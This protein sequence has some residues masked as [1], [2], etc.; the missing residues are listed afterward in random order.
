MLSLIVG[1][2]VL[3]F[4]S[5]TPEGFRT[6][7][8][9]D[10]SSDLDI[11]ISPVTEGYADL[12][13]TRKGKLPINLDQWVEP[14]WEDCP[15]MIANGYPTEHKNEIGDQIAAPMISATAEVASRLGGQEKTFVLHSFLEVPHNAY[16]SGMSGGPVYVPV[17]ESELTPTGIIFEGGPSSKDSAQESIYSGPNSIFIRA[18][19]LSPS[20][21]DEWLDRCGLS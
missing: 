10:E 14:D 2:A 1:R 16:L 18:Y 11:A 21:F 15:M 12:L 6:T 9:T 8:R 3:R 17:S 5:V 4:G 20:I 19:M 13:E 7:F